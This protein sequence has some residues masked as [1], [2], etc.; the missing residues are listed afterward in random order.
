M[1]GVVRDLLNIIMLNSYILDIRSFPRGPVASKQKARKGE[2]LRSR[3]R[4][5]QTLPS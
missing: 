1:D 3:I 4:H 2:S 5:S